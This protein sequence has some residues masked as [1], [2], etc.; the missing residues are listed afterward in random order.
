MTRFVC[1]HG[2]FYQPPRENPW[3]EEVELQDSASPY[4]DWNERITAESYAPNAASR[5][6]DANGNLVNVV[7]NYSKI[8]FNFGPTLLSWMERH[9]PAVYKTI[10]EA[11]A[12]SRNNFSGHGSALGQVYNHLIMPL[13]TTRDKRTQVI[14]GIRD[15]ERRFGRKPEGLWLAETAVD[16]ET[17]DIMAERGIRFGL[18]APRQAA[19]ARLFGRRWRD[20]SGG[21]IDPKR[22]YLCRL[23]S[24]R[25]I[26]LFFYDGSVS[27]EVAFAGLLNSGEKFANRLI[28]A[29]TDGGEEA[30]LVHIATDGETYGHH[31]RH[32]DMALAYC[33]HHIESNGLARTTVYG[34]YLDNFP[35]RHEVEI[36]ENSSWSCAHG[37]ERWR[38]NCG[39]NTGRPEWHQAWRGPLRQSLNWLR[40]ELAAVFEQEAGK[41]L[42]D[43]WQARDDYIEVVLNRERENVEQF[44]MNHASVELTREDQTRA[45]RLLEMQR[46]AMLM[47]TSCGWF[48]DEISG[49]EATQVMQYAARAIQLCEKAAGVSLEPRFTE[50]LER[51]ESNLPSHANGARIYHSLVKP[52]MVDL[53]RVGA[54]YAVSSLFKQYEETD[55]LYSYTAHREDYDLHEAGR[56]KLAIGRAHLRSA[57]TWDEQ[58]ISFAVLHLG[59]HNIVGGVREFRGEELYNR[60][61]DEI[62][63][64]FAKSDLPEMIHLID[65]HFETHNYSLWH[66]FRDEQ[67]KV[68]NH[69]LGDTLE[70]IEG[71]FRRIYDHHYPV[72]QA[73]RELRIPLPPALATPVEYIINSNL[74]RLLAED[75]LDLDQLQNLLEEIDKWGFGADRTSLG[76]HA[77]EKIASLM[78]QLVEDPENLP[79]VKTVGRMVEILKS[80]SLQLDLMK[81]QHLHFVIARRNFIRIRDRAESGDETAREWVEA[82]DRLGTYLQVRSA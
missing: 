6:L 15:F 66:L 12:E 56:Q 45:L 43:P 11:D 57:I 62:K 63:D 50:M 26:T 47:F 44:L 25:E 49:L 38:E 37:I 81:S 72:M 41:V 39:C 59:D 32:G 1:I 77:S 30:Q 24:G 46:H 60:M 18:L 34:E 68:F 4:H 23:P 40:D 35:P 51:A 9:T 70:E 79:L 58:T 65:K 17:L 52:A 54:H 78:Q 61:R 20:V 80:P 3:L 2:H 33:L 71:S 69:I 48:F 14:W 42:A 82:F 27:Q 29:F 22:P 67:R 73:M 13:A 19:R 28:S 55:T 53:M 76:Y 36:I 8:S 74:R 7:N 31:H 21:R 75:A 5:I 10:I 64:A 16:L